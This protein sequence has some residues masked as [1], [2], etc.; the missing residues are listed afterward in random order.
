MMRPAPAMRAALEHGLADAAAADDRDGRAGLDAGGVERRAHTGGDAAADQRELVVGDVGLDL[1]DRRLVARHRL[2]ERAE[3]GHGHVVGAV[4]ALAAQR[5]HH[6]ELG[7]AEV[8][9]VVEAEPAVAARRDERG[10]D[11]VALL[12]VRDLLADLDDRAGA[13]VAEHG[14]G[15]DAAT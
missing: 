12:D 8:R 15:H 6:V 10:D 2:G 5:H 9:L 14:A 3:A 13:L 1:D 7:V 4:G 11:V